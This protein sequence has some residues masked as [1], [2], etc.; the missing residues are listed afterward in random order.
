[1]VANADSPIGL[2]TAYLLFQCSGASFWKARDKRQLVRHFCNWRKTPQG[3]ALYTTPEA[4]IN[5]GRALFRFRPEFLTRGRPVVPLAMKLNAPFGLTPN[6]LSSSGA[7]KFLRLLMMPWL[8]FEMTFLERQTP[9][10]NQTGQAFA[11]QVQACVAAHLAIPAT[12]WTRDDK[13]AFRDT[14]EQQRLSR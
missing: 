5:N 12:R 11:D 4:T 1:M 2:A 13:Y 14:R 3:I 8:E 9:A 6:P 7:M 10:E